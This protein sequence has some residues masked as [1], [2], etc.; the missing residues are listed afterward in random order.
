MYPSTPIQLLVSEAGLVPAYIF[1]D[2]RQ[3]MYIYRLLSLPEDHPAKDILPVSFRKGDR[4]TQ[5]GLPGDQPED[6]FLW[7]S[8]NKASTYEQWLARQFFLTEV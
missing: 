2:H 5:P 6:T 8:N 3:R 7:A 1:L 4:D